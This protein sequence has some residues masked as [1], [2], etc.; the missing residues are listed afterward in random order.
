MNILNYIKL[1]DLHEGENRFNCFFCSDR[2]RRLYVRIE[3]NKLLANCFNCGF[4]Q[5]INLIKP[6]QL[7]K[8][9]KKEKT[10]DTELVD[11]FPFEYKKYLCSMRITPEVLNKYNIK[12]DIKSNRIYI[13]CHKGF[14]LRSISEKP[15]WLSFSVDYFNTKTKLKDKLV[16][17]E[18]VFSAIRVTEA[19]GIFAVAMLGTYL[20]KE[21]AELLRLNRDKEIIIWLDKDKP[22]ME[23]SIK[24]KKA[25]TGYNTKI[26]IEE[27]AKKLS[28]E[29]II[30]CL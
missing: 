5:V 1:E 27:E 12:F 25:L 10:T 13:P 20:K 16:L 2:R 28:E 4:K 22:G 15:K 11:N 23:A 17:T 29:E 19:T 21:V 14:Q 8:Q 18:D 26:I 7:K 9:I 6:V 3:N 30:K 24:I